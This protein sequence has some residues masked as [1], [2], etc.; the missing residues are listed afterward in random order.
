MTDLRIG[1]PPRH[2]ERSEA[3]QE[4]RSESWIASSQ[5]LLATT[6]LAIPVQPKTVSLQN[7]VIGSSATPERA[8]R[9]GAVSV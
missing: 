1:I 9:S 8:A 2:C 4:P 7:R 6:K 3:I 5:E